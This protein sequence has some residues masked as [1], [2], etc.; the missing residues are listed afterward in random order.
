MSHPQ[1]QWN[2]EELEAVQI[3][4]L[5]E[6]KGDI[7]RKVWKHFELLRDALRDEISSDSL[8][9]PKEIDIRKGQVAKGENHL[10]LPFVYLDFPKYFSRSEKCTFRT[11]FWWGKYMVYALILE[12]ALLPQYK[13]KI[14]EQFSIL[15]E[16]SFHLSIA[17]DPWEWR[18]GLPYTLSFDH[19]NREKLIK[20]LNNLTFVKLER[21]IDLDTP[22]FQT[23][24][25][26]IEGLDTFRLLKPILTL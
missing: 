13:K 12:G 3:T 4:R 21:F 6:M 2:N 1:I 20:I 8:L 9:A 14:I 5:F 10:S 26:L 24:K 17:Q 23:G 15:S 7:L 16:A 11:F 22:S 19:Q 18:R 25:L